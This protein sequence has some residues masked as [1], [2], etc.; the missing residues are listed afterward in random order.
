MLLV[1]PGTWGTKPVCPF[2]CRQLHDQLARP[3][4]CW[5]MAHAWLCPAQL[6]KGNS[7]PRPPAP[8][9]PPVMRLA[10][11]PECQS[12]ASVRCMLG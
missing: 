7:P 2:E 10:I 4:E 8:P 12:V 6:A 1:L 9:L 11:L 3:A 5:A